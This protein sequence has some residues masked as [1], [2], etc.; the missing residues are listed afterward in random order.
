MADAA[1][2]ALILACRAVLAGVVGLAAIAKVARPEGLTDSAIALGVPR[3]WAPA[4]AVAVPA[5]EALAASALLVPPLAVA[6][7]ALAGAMLAA[8][9]IAV[10]L[11]VS[12]GRHPVCRCFGGADATAVSGRTL[13]RNLALL[14]LA[15]LASGDAGEDPAV[16]A[17]SVAA[18][19]V[20][21]ALGLRAR[22]DA[23]AA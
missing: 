23:P 7:A 13:A 19:L 18:V 3:R 10:G 1:V 8:F 22:R 6:G 4:A 17:P 5:G 2:T 16:L 15:V 12:R 11:A 14:A 20:A 9:T 21:L